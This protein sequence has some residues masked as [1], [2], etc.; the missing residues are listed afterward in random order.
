MQML[1]IKEIFYVFCASSFALGACIASFLNVVVYRLPLGLSVVFPPSRCPKCSTHI[2]WYNNIPVISYLLLRGRCA[3]C[4]AGIS[5][6]YIIVELLGGALFLGV[7]LRLFA[8]NSLALAMASQS[9]LGAALAFLYL[10]F[11]WV[12]VSL[13]I[14]GSFIDF[15]HKLLPDFTTVGGMWLGVIFWGVVSLT[16]NKYGF[17][18]FARYIPFLY[19]LSGL[20]IGFAL[21]WLIR[22]LGT[23]VF[24]RE[25]MGLGDVFLMGAVGAVS[26]PVAVL[27]SL[28]LSS[29]FGSVVG[30]TLI[31]LSKAKLG[32]FVEIP[33]GPY[34]CMGSLAWIFY[35]PE[36][37]GWYLQLFAR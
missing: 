31:A 27:V 12:W 20:M 5:P 19:S 17:G 10:V 22:F 36:L 28:V 7:F 6:R 16:S 2:A 30:L 32:K 4:S 18:E 8:G 3:S 37:V 29:I 26:G 23:I 14:A 11:L 1:D 25:A 35:G 33:Y 21:M 24:K 34:I 13:M 9:T 15:D